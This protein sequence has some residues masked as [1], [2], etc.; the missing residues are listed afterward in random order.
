MAMHQIPKEKEER[1]GVHG[2][3]AS[4]GVGLASS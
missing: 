3:T 2:K 1:V 4:L